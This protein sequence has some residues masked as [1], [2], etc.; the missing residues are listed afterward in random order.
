MNK[1][2][3]FVLRKSLKNCFDF[4]FLLF[5]KICE[6]WLIVQSIAL[7]NQCFRG[8]LC[9]EEY[10]LESIQ[11]KLMKKISRINTWCW[12]RIDPETL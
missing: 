1:N 6:S 5:K 7:N 10:K 2:L 8:H 3:E 4:C 11:E 12:F 9:N